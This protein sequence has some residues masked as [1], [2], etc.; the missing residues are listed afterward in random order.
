MELIV[1]VSV[2]WNWGPAFD[3]ARLLTLL[4]SLQFDGYQLVG[5]RYF[6]PPDPFFKEQLLHK[7]IFTVNI[8][9]EGKCECICFRGYNGPH[10]A[11][12]VQVLN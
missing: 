7:K 2:K 6:P 10:P 5:T 12:I 3:K 4:L 8:D 1:D 11:D 9:D